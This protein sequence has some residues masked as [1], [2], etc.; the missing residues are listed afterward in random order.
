MLVEVAE[1]LLEGG[2]FLARVGGGGPGGDGRDQFLA[3]P[4]FGDEAEDATRTDLLH[5]LVDREDAGERDDRSVGLTVRGAHRLE[6]A[7][8]AG[9]LSGAAT[10]TVTIRDVSDSKDRV[11]ATVDSDGNRTAITTDVT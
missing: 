7:A 11:V 2:V 8:A 9:K 6:V 5:G 1:F 3:Q 10:T 4:G